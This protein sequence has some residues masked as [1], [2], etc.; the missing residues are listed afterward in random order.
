M[1][2]QGGACSLGDVTAAVEHTWPLGTLQGEP[3]ET[4]PPGRVSGPKRGT[5]CGKV[6]GQAHPELSR[7]PPRACLDPLELWDFLAPQALQALW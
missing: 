1:G 5:G 3:G 4:G 2:A 7:L 6:E